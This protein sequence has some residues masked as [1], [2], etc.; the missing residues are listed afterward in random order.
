MK[1]KRASIRIITFIIVVFLLSCCFLRLNADTG[2][3][4]DKKYYL[5][6]SINPSENEYVSQSSLSSSVSPLSALTE[7]SE[8]ESSCREQ[9]ER[10][11][12]DSFLAES[13]IADYVDIEEFYETK[14]MF[15]I[16]AQETLSSYVFQNADGTKTVYMMAENVKYVDERGSVK[17]KDIHLTASG[18]N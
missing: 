14:P 18:K 16:E 2:S 11:C 7:I 1:L 4:F 9:L 8:I 13:K 3:L 12:A 6:K 10:R 15:R 17:E 5:D